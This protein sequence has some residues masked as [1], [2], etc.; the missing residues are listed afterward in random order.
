M[1]IT[2]HYS[3]ISE[4]FAHVSCTTKLK[5]IEWKYLSLKP[6]LFLK[7]MLLRT[8]AD[9]YFTQRGY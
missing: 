6:E 9:Q 8:T 4:L 7:C 3:K 1:N 2:P 5:Y